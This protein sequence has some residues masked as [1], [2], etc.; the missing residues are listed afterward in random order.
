MNKKQIKIFKINRRPIKNK[1]V[2]FL[3][4]IK[5]NKKPFSNNKLTKYN[6]KEIII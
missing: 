2:R 6:L 5:G 3:L 4:L 1:Y